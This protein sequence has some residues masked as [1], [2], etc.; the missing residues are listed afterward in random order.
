MLSIAQHESDIIIDSINEMNSIMDQWKLM[1]F[2]DLIDVLAANSHIATG[3]WIFLKK[4][5]KKLRFILP[6]IDQTTVFSK[7]FS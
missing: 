2:G 5:K 3:C 4:K 6:N 1:I 7:V